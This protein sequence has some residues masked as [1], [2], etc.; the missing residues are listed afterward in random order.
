MPMGDG[1]GPMGRGP[2]AGWGGGWCRGLRGGFG[3]HGW[4]NAYRA[5]GVPGWRRAGMWSFRDRDLLPELDE[6]G[7][8]RRHAEE[9]ERELEQVRARLTALGS[10]HESAD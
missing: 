9:L 5:T 6:A 8:L 1:T 2:F 4:R 3:G 10:E 7:W